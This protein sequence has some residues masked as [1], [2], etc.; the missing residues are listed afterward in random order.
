MIIWKTNNIESLA[1]MTTVKKEDKG[2]YK[3]SY[4]LNNT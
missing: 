4:K 2:I 3:Q 1:K